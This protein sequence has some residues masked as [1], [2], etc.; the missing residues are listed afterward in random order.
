MK[1]DYLGLFKE[2]GFSIDN[3]SKASMLELAKGIDLAMLPFVHITDNHGIVLL[4]KDQKYYRA[5]I[6]TEKNEIRIEAE[7]PKSVLENIPAVVISYTNDSSVEKVFVDSTIVRDRE[8]RRE[9]FQFV[10][11]KDE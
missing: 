9:A 3:I 10:V 4:S 1:Y 8:V 11:T 2:K 7:E 6:H 5:T